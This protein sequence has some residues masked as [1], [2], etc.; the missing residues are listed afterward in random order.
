MI[1]SKSTGK[2]AE[3]ARQTRRRMLEA[4]GKLFVER[5]YGATALQDIASEAAVAVQTIYFTFGNKRTLLKEVVDVTIA[6]DDQPV[7]TM[8]R[9]WFRDM[10]AAPTAADQ[11]RLHVHGTGEV[12]HRVAP[13]I[14]VLDTAT[15][16]DPE[17]ADLWDDSP[18]PR[19]VVQ[20]AAAQVLVTKPGARPGVSAEH[21]TDL[22]FAL[23]SPELYLVLVNQRG[24]TRR[25]WE[26]WAGLTLH[27]Q[28][29]A[30]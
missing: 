12:M 30:T 23:L 24:W 21:A 15:A 20:T 22:L 9:P 27:A 7:A 8:D 10:L 4:A 1:Q 25:Q 29:C 11:L 3:K 2:R 19:L 17:I 16:I 18:D 28:L 26:E 13:I 14:R 5:G 6:G